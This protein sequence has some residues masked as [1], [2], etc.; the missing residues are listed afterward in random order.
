MAWTLTPD[1]STF[2]PRGFWPH[3]DKEKF[4]RKQPPWR[5]P[6]KR[7]PQESLCY[8]DCV[9]QSFYYAK[10]TEVTTSNRYDLLSEEED[11]K[12]DQDPSTDQITP[13]EVVVLPDDFTYDK[14]MLNND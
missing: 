1:S 12:N 11:L 7:K 6:K 9:N 10:G 14:F 2:S 13:T 8:Y 3:P 4:I 5:I